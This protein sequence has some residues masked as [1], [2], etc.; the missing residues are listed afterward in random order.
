M[1]QNTAPIFELVP[2]SVGVE[3]V[4]ADTTTKK[5]IYTGGT[6]GSR[7]DAIFVS[8]SDT[9]GVNL[10]FYITVGGTD[11]YIGNVVV[12]IGS[13]YTTVARTEAMSTL[14]PAL[15]YLILADAAILKVASVTTVTSGKV[16]DIVAVGGDY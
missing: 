7:I 15:G 12:T 11:Y 2:V 4:P 8:S 9:A 16:V 6:N 14:S 1:A 5:T 10:A 13:G 3:I